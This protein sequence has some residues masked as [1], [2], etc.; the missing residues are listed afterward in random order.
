M[1]RMEWSGEDEGIDM[2]LEARPEAD[3]PVLYL[4]SLD[5]FMQEFEALAELRSSVVMRQRA[6]P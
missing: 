5:E 2:I 1:H 3:F 4:A 6:A